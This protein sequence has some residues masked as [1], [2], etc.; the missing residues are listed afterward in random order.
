MSAILLELLF[1]N[2]EKGRD[3]ER[4][5][6]LYGDKKEDSEQQKLAISAY[7]AGTKYNNY[8]LI[9]RGS[10]V[11]NGMIDSNLKNIEYTWP[12]LEKRIYN[13]RKTRP[14]GQGCIFHFTSHDF[15]P[16]E[17]DEEYIKEAQEYLSYEIDQE[18]NKNPNEKYIYLGALWDSESRPRIGSPIIIEAPSMLSAS[19]I[20][21]LYF[22]RQPNQTTLTDWCP[23][24]YESNIIT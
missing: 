11:L 9:F 12:V 21:D 24:I 19:C 16:L 6:I 17:Y 1:K 20:T 10:I 22:E 13:Q 18:A 23:P 3:S 7:Q 2:I 14:R 4:E 8:R 5:I 15:D